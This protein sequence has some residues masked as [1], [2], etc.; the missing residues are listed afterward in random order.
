M[1]LI[2]VEN[3]FKYMII[4]F[5]ISLDSLRKVSDLKRLVLRIVNEQDIKLKLRHDLL[6]II[7]Q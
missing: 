6:K 5:P 3:K 4:S 1:K 7:N 2:E